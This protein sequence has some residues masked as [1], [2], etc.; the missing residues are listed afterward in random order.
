MPYN[1]SLLVTYLIYS[2]VYMSV[3]T[4]QFICPLSYSLLTVSLC[5]TS[6]TPMF[7]V[8]AIL[9][10]VK[11]YLIVLLFVFPGWLWHW[12][13]FLVPVSHLNIFFAKISIQALCQ[14]FNWILCM[15]VCVCVFC[16]WVIWVPYIFLILTTLSDS[17]LQIFFLFY[18]CRFI[19]LMVSLLHRVF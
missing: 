15:F 4:F 10:S 1:R 3:P 8:I 12:T 9:T 7:F 6:V 14:I 11:C 18:S 13:A 19:L 2:S 17:G 16:C 5:S